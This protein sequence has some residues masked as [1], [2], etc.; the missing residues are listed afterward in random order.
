MNI[1]PLTINRPH[2]YSKRFFRDMIKSFEEYIASSFSP[3]SLNESVDKHM[4]KTKKKCNLVFITKNPT[5]ETS[6]GEYSKFKKSCDKYGVD[7]HHIDVDKVKYKLTE[8]GDIEIEGVGNFSKNDTLFMFR[9]AIKIKSTDEEK[10]ISQKNV[11]DF[12]RMLK[13]NGFFISNDAKVARICKSKLSTFEVLEQNDVSTIDTIEIDRNMF[14]LKN[15]DGVNNMNK[16][17]AK[18]NLQLPVV[19]KVVDGTQGVGCFKCQDLNVMASIVQYLV[20]TKGKCIVQ[21]FCDIDY[22]VRVH[23]FCKSLN[24]ETADIDDFVVVGTMKRQRV[25]DDF[26]TNYSLGGKISTYHISDEEKELAKKAAKAIGSVWVGVDICH[27]KITGKDYVI[28]CNSSPALA[29]ISSIS[30]K[31]PTDIIVKH[32]KKTLSGK[33]DDKEDIDDRDVVGYYET[34]LLDGIEI[35]ACNDSGNSATSAIKSNFFEID[36]DKVTFEI[37]GH[38]ITKKIIRMKSILHGGIKSDERPLVHMDIT[39]NDKV[40][41]NVDVVVRGLTKIEKEREE[42]TGKKLGGKKILLSTDVIDKLGL[43]IHPDRKK[44]FLQTSKPKKG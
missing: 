39:F 11:K 13:S 35:K 6:H 9:H 2:K 4:N 5:S 40:I 33:L 27:D 12:K 19:V 24:P 22:D 26:R 1:N 8:D 36:G 38:K 30:K 37:M 44:E 17:L 23:V 41:K 15:L 28:E 7:I 31:Q 34:I 18:H 20:K 3:I 14:G 21:P 16:F 25:Q 32:I 43:I 10:Q 42:K 29:G